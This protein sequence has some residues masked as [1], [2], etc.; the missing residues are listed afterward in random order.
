MPPHTDITHSSLPK[1]LALTL[2][3]AVACTPAPESDIPRDRDGN[4]P[5]VIVNNTPVFQSDLDF[6]QQNLPDFLAH[7]PASGN[8]SP[9]LASMINVT[10]LAQEAEKTLSP[11]QIKNAIDKIKKNK[12]A[13]KLSQ[14][15][16]LARIFLTPRSIFEPREYTLSY[17]QFLTPA[18]ATRFRATYALIASA[19][20]PHP[21]KPQ[22]ANLF[23]QLS[24]TMSY[25]PPREKTFGPFNENKINRF[26]SH[27]AL[28]ILNNTRVNHISN[29][30][31]CLPHIICLVYIINKKQPS[32]LTLDEALLRASTKHTTSPLQ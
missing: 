8:N 3:I 7:T 18:F 19:T 27:E 31:E 29:P 14:N 25:T 15:E 9:L 5:I 30:I 2:C 4:P 20:A 17:A 1:T 23:A 32:L 21:A 11:E 16:K 24:A 26:T 12:P 10:L 28:K 13:P 6:A 22:N